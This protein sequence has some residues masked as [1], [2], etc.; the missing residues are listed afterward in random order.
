LVVD[1]NT[2]IL[3]I[4]SELI[5]AAGY[6]PI[7]ATGGRECLEKIVSD[8]PDLVLLDINM[9]DMDGWTVLRT[10]KEKGL[11]ENVKIMMLTATTEIGTDIFGLQD[12]VSGYIR[13]PFNN[14]ELAA[15]LRE[16][17]GDQPPMKE[18]PKVEKDRKPF[19]SMRRKKD[20]QDST[21]EVARSSAKVY[22]LRRG[23]SYLVKE[24]KPHK[25]FEI[26]VDQVTHN[27]QGLCVTRQHPTILR[28]EWGLEKSPIIWLS[29]QLG[30]VYV[31]PSNIGILSDTI[32][33]FV[34]KSGDS[35]IL[36]DGVEFLIVNN[37]FDKVLRM[38]HHIT[39]AVM[40]NRS[41]LIVSIDPRTMETRELA[42][43]ERNME[44]IETEEP[45]PRQ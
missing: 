32:I 12:V 42:L 34:E 38:I 28:K 24:T 7:T 18:E 13:K 1:D 45:R 25:S 4:V 15:R 37:D 43:L 23:F 39:E 22:E 41:R 16:V 11:T 40:E 27:I 5:S 36:I 19:F 35:V 2:A 20:E 33:R 31:N 17:L 3:E 10:L 30:K 6:Q 21:M 9:P 14:D 44:I 29:N 26:F 8:K